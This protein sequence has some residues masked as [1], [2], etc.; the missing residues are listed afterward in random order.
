M[1]PFIPDGHRKSERF[2]PF[3]TNLK[4]K[5]DRY[6]TKLVCFAP[7]LHTVTERTSELVVYVK[8]G[9]LSEL[10]LMLVI[11]AQVIFLQ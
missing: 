6:E 8:L 9:R 7:E 1:C 5:A 10:F 11:V 4:L 2:R 3:Q